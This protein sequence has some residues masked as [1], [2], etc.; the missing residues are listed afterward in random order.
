[1]CEKPGA[2]SSK[3]VSKRA[4]PLE[5]ITGYTN[6]WTTAFINTSCLIL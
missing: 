4:C 6:K 2:K 3:D 1:M 5:V